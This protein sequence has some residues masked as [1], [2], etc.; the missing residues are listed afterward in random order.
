MA[1]VP[2]TVGELAAWH[3][4]LRRNSTAAHCTAQ[5]NVSHFP[6]RVAHPAPGENGSKRGTAEPN[7]SAAPLDLFGMDFEAAYAQAPASV[8]QRKLIIIAFFNLATKRCNFQFRIH[9][10]SVSPPH[11]PRGSVAA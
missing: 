5:P 7:G 10:F 1:Y 2:E 8:E 6:Q 11:R 4:V 3:N 9:Y